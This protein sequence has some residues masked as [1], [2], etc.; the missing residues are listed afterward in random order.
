MPLTT[1]I[2]PAGAFAPWLPRSWRVPARSGATPGH[3]ASSSWKCAGVRLP[4]RRCAL[5]ADSRR[6]TVAGTAL[7]ARFTRSTDPHRRV[8]FRNVAAAFPTRT[9]E[10]HARAIVR[11]TF[12]HFGR[13]LFQ[14]LKFNTLTDAQM[15]A[16]S[17]KAKSACVRRMRT[18]R[19]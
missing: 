10:E 6:W 13:L 8:A 18:A 16:W 7:T 2:E 12:E 14:L 15:L 11:G 4:H 5:D 9:P 17:L 19:A 3:D 1:Q